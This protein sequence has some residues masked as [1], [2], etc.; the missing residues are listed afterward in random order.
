MPGSAALA[1]VAVG[2]LTATMMNPATAPGAQATGNSGEVR[3]NILFITADDLSYRDIRHM[4]HLNRAMREQ[5]VT[6]SDAQAPT[7]IC[8]PA[9]A[10]LLSG[11]YAHNHGA[12]TISGP[13][14]GYASFDDRRTVPAALEASGYTTLFAGKY[15]N[16]Y[17]IDGT[18]YDVPP[19]WSHWRGFVD[20][21]TYSFFDPLMNQDGVVRQTSGYT[22][23]VTTENARQLIEG[24]GTKK[25]WFAWVNYVAPH[26]GSPIGRA[27][28]GYKMTVPAPRDLGSYAQVRLPDRPN[29]FWSAK[30]SPITSRFNPR[31]KKSLRL[32]YQRRL[33]AVKGLDRAIGRTFSYLR[34][35]HLLSRTLVIFSSDNGYAVG[36]H[37]INGKLWGYDEPVR[38]PVMM[39]GPGVP[40]GTTVRTPVTNP[41]LAATVLG[42]ANVR[43][44]RPLDG[45]DIRPWLGAPTH[46]RV[47]PLEAWQVGNGNRLLY[48]GVRVGDWTYL[49]HVN[50]TVELY[51][52][53][54]DPYEVRNLAGRRVYVAEQAALARLTRKY[55][56]CAGEECPQLLQPADEP[57]D[58]DAM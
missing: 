50:G 45:I 34:K 33:E 52:R 36:E 15:L 54:S 16:G 29:M 53:E 49:R 40:R 56:D 41:D 39:R 47:V 31:Q 26:T 57:L 55:R 7:P 21:S 22:T 27:P 6:F 20:N 17:G 43:P 30:S 23:D 46:V 28:A 37:N 3:P 14:G 51:D 44:P 4:P 18:A 5:G 38:I 19:G 11:Q 35:Q 13:H 42:V 1:M 24:A 10:S 25:P 32:V 12:R 48:R 2:A 8:V 9:R 58:L